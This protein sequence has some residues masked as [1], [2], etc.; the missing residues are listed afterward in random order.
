MSSGE[1]V[2]NQ[3][4][5]GLVSTWGFRAPGTNAQMQFDTRGGLLVSQHGGQY[6]ELVRRGVCFY[7]SAVAQTIPVTGSTPTSLFTIYNP[8]QSNVNLEMIEVN[9]VPVLVTTV[10]DCIGVYFSNPT[11]TA[12]T[13]TAGAPTAGVVKNC[14]LNGSSGQA[15][16][17]TSFLLTAAPTLA[18]IVGG[19]GATTANY[20]GQV[21]KDFEG[22]L[23]VPPGVSVHLLMTTAATTGSGMSVDA[24]WAE[25]PLS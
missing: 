15:Q 7:A 10:V 2:G 23:I 13:F 16:F 6:A 14:V 11:L 1:W 20:L 3:W 4:M 24:L 9:A 12:A 8:P 5:K 21:C 25:I 19:W 17:F 22:A 18:R